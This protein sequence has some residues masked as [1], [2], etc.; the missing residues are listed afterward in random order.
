M[1]GVVLDVK[2][3]PHDRA[4][5]VP[6]EL[7]H[8]VV[9]EKDVVF[10]LY[11]R[12]RPLQHP[13][14]EVRELFIVGRGELED[15]LEL[16]Q[17]DLELAEPLVRLEEQVKFDGIGTFQHP[18]IQNM[19]AEKVAFGYFQKIRFQLFTVLVQPYRS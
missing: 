3:D 16:V 14:F 5:A 15:V 12:P 18:R 13:F 2:N 1:V 11:L 10:L 19:V 17:P 8:L 4:F 6:C 9:G 7:P